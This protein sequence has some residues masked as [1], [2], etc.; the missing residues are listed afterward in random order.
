MPLS[1][2]KTNETPGLPGIEMHF[3][4]E[5]WIIKPRYNNRVIQIEWLATQGAS[6]AATTHP[7]VNTWLVK[8]MVARQTAE[9]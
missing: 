8:D 7:R 4:L 2:P 9:S 3:A 1:P 6:G 5:S